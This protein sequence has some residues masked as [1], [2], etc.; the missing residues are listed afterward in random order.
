MMSGKM[1]AGNVLAA[2]SISDAIM[3]KKLKISM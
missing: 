2:K 1:H 3:A